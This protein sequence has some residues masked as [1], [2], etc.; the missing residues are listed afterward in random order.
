M[1]HMA[2]ANKKQILDMYPKLVVSDDGLDP[3]DAIAPRAKRRNLHT[4]AELNVIFTPG[5]R[6]RMVYDRICFPRPQEC[7][8]IYSTTETVNVITTLPHQNTNMENGYSNKLPLVLI[9][10]EMINEKILLIQRS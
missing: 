4:S 5:E 7:N 9:K 2:I 1:L 8:I 10:K 6:R 3:A